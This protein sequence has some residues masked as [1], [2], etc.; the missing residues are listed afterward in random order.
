MKG[1]RYGEAYTVLEHLR[2][3]PLQAA[4]TFG[5]EMQLLISTIVNEMGYKGICITF[6]VRSKLRQFSLAVIKMFRYSLTIGTATRTG[7]SKRNLIKQTSLE[8]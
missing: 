3:T 1:N 5:H 4:S 2:E 6:T 8:D 7:F